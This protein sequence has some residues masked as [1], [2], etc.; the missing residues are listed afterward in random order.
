[1]NYVLTKETA[2]LRWKA[3]ER[4]Y[5]S[6]GIQQLSSKIEVF[7]SYLVPKGSAKKVTEIVSD[8]STLQEDIKLID[9]TE[10]SLEK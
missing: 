6:R 7:S 4:L 10:I 2:G 1:L 3:L 8:L 5:I 9:P